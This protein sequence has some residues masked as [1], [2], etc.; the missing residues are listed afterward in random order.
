MIR[1]GQ[2]H[3]LTIFTWNSEVCVSVCNHVCALF[4]VSASRSDIEEA[5]ENAVQNQR[6]EERTEEGLFHMVTTRINAFS[7]LEMLKGQGWCLSI[8]FFL[9]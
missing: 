7:L 9:S 3:T 1:L 4:Q 8:I 2:L 5:E 6:A